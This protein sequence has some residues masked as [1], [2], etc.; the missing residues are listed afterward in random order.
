MSGSVSTTG[1]LD[2]EDAAI[3]VNQLLEEM[4]AATSEDGGRV[5][6]FLGDGVL[7]VFGALSVHED[8]AER[9]IRTALR[10]REQ[11]RKLG[12]AAT[13]GINT[14]EV[15]FG[16]IGSA[17]HQEVTVMG[18][19]VNLAARLQGRAAPDD[20]LVGETTWRQ[21]R[22]AFGFERI[23]VDIKGINEPVAAYRVLD[24][25]VFPEKRRGLEG[26]QSPLV[27]RDEQLRLLL[28]DLT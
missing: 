9:A 28:A 27:G 17:L 5:D 4:V 8:D 24:A 14:G 10:I 3:L 6:R 22:G 21:T 25:R 2:A 23:L 19:A 18:P 20:V 16:T 7:A 11:A 26:L 13:A 1:S 12:L 15:Y